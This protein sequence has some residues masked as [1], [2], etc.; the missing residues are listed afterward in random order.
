MEEASSAFELELFEQV[1][2]MPGT[3]L[4]RVVGHPRMDLPVHQTATLTF[5][6]GR[7]TYRLSALPG[8]IPAAGLL[9]LAFMAPRALL[10]EAATF[11]LSL[12]DSISLPLPPPAPGR[13]LSGPQDTQADNTAARLSDARNAVI[14]AL[15]DALADRAALLAEQ[16]EEL[17]HTRAD[18]QKAREDLQ[19]A[20]EQL[21]RAERGWQQSEELNVELLQRIERLETRIDRAAGERASAPESERTL[22]NR[23]TQPLPAIE[24]GMDQV[25]EFGAI[26]AASTSRQQ[27]PEFE[28]WMATVLSE[29]SA[30]RGSNEH[31]TAIDRVLEELEAL[32]ND[33]GAIRSEGVPPSDPEAA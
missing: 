6:A 28:R 21:Q 14:G 9:T 17:Q 16:E 33:E 32:E 15:E 1:D 8:P 19:Q 7:R 18:L 26:A 31:A 2:A 22:P 23:D 13:K 4:L 27:N 5:Q 20:R 29:L 24:E 12:G 25:P 3:T 10:D 11:E 30:E